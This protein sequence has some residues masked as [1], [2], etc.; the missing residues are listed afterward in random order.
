[1]REI[2]KR[3]ILGKCPFHGKILLPTKSMFSKLTL[4]AFCTC[5]V[6]FAP[7]ASAQANLTRTGGVL[8]NVL[9][10]SLEGAPGKIYVLL[11][12]PSQGPTPLSIIDP[13]D[14]RSMDVGI[15]LLNRLVIGSFD[16]AGNATVN[17]P[18]P[19]APA[20]SGIPIYT[21]MMTVPGS[22]TIVDEISNRTDFVLGLPGDSHLALGELSVETAGY[23][24]VVLDDG[25][26]LLGGG[27]VV[28]GLGAT[29]PS[30][31][32]RIYNPQTQGF[33][34]LAAS[35]TYPSITAA[36]TKLS[37][38]RVL[39]CGGIGATD[40]V[41]S[42]ASI[43]D[44]STGLTTAAASMPVPRAQHTATLLADGRVFVTGGVKAL[45][46]A[47]LL[48]ALGDIL[49]SSTIYDPVGNS[50][51]AA[52]SMPQPAIG[53][54]ATRL[55]SGRVLITGGLEI[56]SLFGVPIPS[57]TARCLFFNPATGTMTSA[58]SLS[59]VRA[60]HGQIGLSD[61]R[62]LVAGGAAGD[63]LTQ[64]FFSVA[65]CRVFNEAT[66]SW[67]SVGDL[68]EV[69]TY[70]NLV[71]AGGMVHVLSGVGTIDLTTLSGSPVVGIASADLTSFAWTSSGT[72]VF[73]RPLSAALAVDGGERIVVLGPGDNGTAV[74]D[75]TAE[76]FIP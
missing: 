66:N 27:G 58:P 51:S 43:F 38:G 22:P 64:S 1:M 24:S 44:P 23:T 28:N 75:R 67:T 69:R 20:L 2:A 73:A 29:V 31:S 5:A 59:G 46:S 40:S 26:V 7:Q 10:Y 76:V 35:L 9:S 57:I 49:G 8:G 4:S 70:P 13:L 42:G 36:G 19:A 34:D 71:E 48:S 50:W 39:F 74:V 21:Q 45:N 60:L 63:V 47:D 65:T 11:P 56:G 32:L 33:E 6:L 54:S 62:V 12:S 30:T 14:P 37:D 3:Y 25:R 53:H 41:L 16:G 17:F 52:A 15:E 55:P 18:L 61:G 68:P 72:M